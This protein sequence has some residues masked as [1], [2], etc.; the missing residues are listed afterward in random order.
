MTGLTAGEEYSARQFRSDV[1]FVQSVYGEDAE[2]ADLTETFI[3]KVVA[4]LLGPLQTGGRNIKPTLC[5]GDL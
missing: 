5:H 1:S 2:L 4:W 3:P